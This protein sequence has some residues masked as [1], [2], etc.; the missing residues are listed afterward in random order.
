MSRVCSLFFYDTTQGFAQHHKIAKTWRHCS[1]SPRTFLFRYGH[2][3]RRYSC[4]ESQSIYTLYLFLNRRMRACPQKTSAGTGGLITS[5]NKLLPSPFIQPSDGT[6]AAKL[7]DNGPYA[8]SS[9]LT[10][11]VLFKLLSLR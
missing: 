1:L 2:T 4:R 7:P 8:M 6:V 10:A 11:V 5:H 9:S 3:Q